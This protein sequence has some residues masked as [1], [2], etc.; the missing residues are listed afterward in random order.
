MC[1]KPWS[2]HAADCPVGRHER[3]IVETPQW[4]LDLRVLASELL[5]PSETPVGKSAKAIGGTLLEIADR[6]TTAL[7]I[8]E[9]LEAS[10]PPAPITPEQLRLRIAGYLEGAWVPESHACIEH[11]ILIQRAA[12]T[13]DTE[14]RR[15]T[16]SQ[17]FVTAQEELRRALEDAD[18]G[19]P[20]RP[21]KHT[22]AVN[23]ASDN[24]YAALKDLP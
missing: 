14:I 24:L 13:L 3:S 15:R 10:G 23:I 19:C 8:H 7:G 11:I 2:N 21:C 1:E 22:R 20:H 5:K 6:A 4:L 12:S 18:C 9:P 16:R 17:A